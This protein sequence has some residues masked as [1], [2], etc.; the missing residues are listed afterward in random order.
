[1]LID[2]PIVRTSSDTVLE[3]RLTTTL[4]VPLLPYIMSV[5][6]PTNSPMLGVLFRCLNSI[7]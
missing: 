7:T 3:L 2:V 5:M 4:C 1:M 6:R